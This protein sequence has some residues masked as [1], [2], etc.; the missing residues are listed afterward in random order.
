MAWIHY[1]DLASLLCWIVE[2][3]T[4]R[5][6]INAVAP[7]PVRTRDFARALGKALHRPSLVPVPMFALRMLLGELAESVTASQRVVPEVALRHG[8]EFRYGDL[9]RALRDLVRK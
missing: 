1:E 8:F 7:E 2:Q 3:K 5:G 9:D 4:V 6:P